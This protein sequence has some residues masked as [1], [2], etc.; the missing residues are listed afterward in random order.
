MKFCRECG[1]QLKDS[2]KFCPECGAPAG[3]PDSVQQVR[4]KEF[5]CPVCSN[6]VLENSKFCKNCG[7][8][9][10]SGAAAPRQ[11]VNMTA[12]FIG[13]QSWARQS[14]NQAAPPAAKPRSK[15]WI[16]PTVLGVLLA[17]GMAV[18]GFFLFRDKGD[19][20]KGGKTSALESVSEADH[21]HSKK[22]EPAVLTKPEGRYIITTIKTDG[23][24][25]DAKYAFA[26]AGLDVNEYYLE[27]NR[28]GTGIMSVF[29]ETGEFTWDDQN[30]VFSNGQKMKMK[31][32]NDMVT[33][34][35]GGNEFIFGK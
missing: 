8:K 5:L 32:E 16:L 6:P 13:R 33:L 14:A 34:I 7:A 25:E 27:F 9:L 22:E 35:D 4:R 10:S 24:T 15:R 23:I 17:A 18:G 1:S 30:V 11:P 21:K 28:D 2:T 20:P 31:F 29:G 26:Y 12:D 3:P 19:P